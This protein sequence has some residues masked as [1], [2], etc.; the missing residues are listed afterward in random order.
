MTH[1]HRRRGRDRR[2]WVHI[3][4]DTTGFYPISM[5]EEVA[6]W[7]AIRGVNPG[8]FGGF[9]RSPAQSR[10]PRKIAE[11]PRSSSGGSKE[12]RR[13]VKPLEALDAEKPIE[14]IA[15]GDYARVARLTSSLEEPGAA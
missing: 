1:A 11:L 6:T 5:S 9:P 12:T 4:R 7:V 14:L 3:K 13:V 15:R 2:K 10:K 8:R